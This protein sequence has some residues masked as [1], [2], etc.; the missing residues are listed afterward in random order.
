M[1]LS[2][3]VF[4]GESRKWIPELAEKAKKLNVNA[5][6]VAGTD[7]GPVISQ[8][9]KERIERLVELGVKEG[10]KLV[11]DGRCVKVSGYEK[12]NFVAPKILNRCDNQHGMLS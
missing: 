4:V 12:G 2:T 5:G 3:A 11:L 9:A 10:A 6:D 7:V 8:M 1:A